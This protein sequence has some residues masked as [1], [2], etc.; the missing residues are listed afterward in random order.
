MIFSPSVEASL[1][2]FQRY[3]LVIKLCAIHCTDF[4]NTNGIKYRLE[5][6]MDILFH[7]KWYILMVVELWR[8]EEQGSF[9]DEVKKDLDVKQDSRFSLVPWLKKQKRR[10]EMLAFKKELLAFLSINQGHDMRRLIISNYQD[11]DQ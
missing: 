9:W 4:M 7:N 6:N 10:Q 1:Y 2:L 8:R 11:Q 3:N 5:E